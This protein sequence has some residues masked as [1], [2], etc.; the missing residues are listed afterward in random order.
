MP[1][2]AAP[3]RITAA[4][5]RRLKPQPKR[6]DPELLSSAHRAWRAEVLRRAGYRCEWIDGGRRCERRAPEH[7]LFADHIRERRDGGAALDPANGQALCGSHH[8]EKTAIQRAKRLMGS[9]GA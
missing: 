1:V 4:D 7:R 3:P 8:T 9:G 6:A 2:K 5:S